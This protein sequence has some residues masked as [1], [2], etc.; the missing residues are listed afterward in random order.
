MGRDYL[1]DGGMGN[2]ASDVR[3]RELSRKPLMCL[4]CA[5]GWV[6]ATFVK[7]RNIQRKLGLEML[8]LR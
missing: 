6:E 3:Q 7:I 5:V 4:V 1:G 8:G 2:G